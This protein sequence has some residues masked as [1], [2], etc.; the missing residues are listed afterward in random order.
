MKHT[1]KLIIWIALL[2]GFTS[3]KS[4]KH[5]V[6]Q[7]K[8]ITKQAATQQLLAFF[9][10][11]NARLLGK[12]NQAIVNYESF[13]KKYP[14]QAV[15]YFQL[16]RL[17]FQQRQIEQSIQHIEKAYTLDTENPY[18]RNQFIQLQMHAGNYVKAQQACAAWVSREP[19]NAAA[20]L[21]LT[22][23][24]LK[25]NHWD[26]ALQSI[27]QYQQLLGAQEDVFA[28]K[29]YIFEQ[30]KQSDSIAGTLKQW[31][32]Y[33]PNDVNPL[34]QLINFYEQQ[35]S[36]SEL[37]V[38]TQLAEN[39]FSQDPLILTTLATIYVQQKDTMA[40]A[41]I[42]ERV[43][44][45]DAFSVDQKISYLQV[46]YS[47][48]YH[49][50]Q[51][52]PQVITWVKSWAAREPQNRQIT[53]L[54][55]GVLQDQHQISEAI[56]VYQNYMANDSSDVEILAQLCSL[57]LAQMH[58]DTVIQYAQ[59]ALTL[60]QQSYLFYFYEGYAALQLGRY[61]QALADLQ[62]A[63]VNS[64]KKDVNL[65]VQILSSLGDVYH[66]QK[67]FDKSDQ[68]FTEVLTLVPNDATLLN[69]YAY[70]LSERNVRLNDAQQMSEKSLALQ[71]D[72]KSFLDT[73]AWILFQ[74]GKYQEALV[75]GLRAI[76]EKLGENDATLYDHVGDIYNKLQMID[77]AIYYWRK[78]V[79][80][81]PKNQSIQQKIKIKGIHE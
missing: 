41:N 60:Q 10:A 80:L 71:P 74:Q 9:D 24:H 6:T 63:K 17:Y 65:Y 4:P 78:S 43:L 22:Q 30:T 47:Q 55:A 67:D 39:R 16:S 31:I 13:V 44:K 62:N 72:T 58:F 59:L 3:C 53:M 57:H 66:L 76:D 2:A 40:L 48:T 11:E 37:A 79:S 20:W 73:Y 36:F 49:Q 34:L 14:S 42:V 50:K 54:Y 46:I 69:N 51:F 7:H 33:A 75:Y 68:M 19:S 35:A 1:L 61:E 70:Y 15:G 12:N 29:K 77:K 64:N 8:N 45:H 21:Q 52:I 18:Y 32:Q 81:N 27:R 23:I 25:S 5:A 56:S 38:Y 26:Q 28:I